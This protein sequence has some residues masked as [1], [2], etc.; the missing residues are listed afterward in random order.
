[1]PETA[2]FHEDFVLSLGG[3]EN[4]LEPWL[5]DVT[6]VARARVYRNNVVTACADAVVKGFS[7]V[8][9]LVGGEFMRATAVA[10]VKAHPPQSP[11][12]ALYGDGFPDFLKTF[13]PAQQ[14][15]YLADIARL[16]RAWSESFFALNAKPLQPQDIADLNEAD[17]AKLS[18]GLHPSARMV[19]SRWNTHHIWKANK[20]DVEIKTGLKLEEVPTAAVTWFGPE[21]VADRA[22]NESEHALLQAIQTGASLGTAIARGEAVDAQNDLPAFFSEML[23]RGIFGG[24]KEQ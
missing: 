14:L 6:H 18:P 13:P 22:L 16:D 19:I 20:L 3:D 8:E 23:A 17:L 12:L 24:I 10:F 9:R 21:G 2:S 7:T 5:Q 1:M 11:V 4:V 15:P